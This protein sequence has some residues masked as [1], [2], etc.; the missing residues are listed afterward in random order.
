[1][2]VEVRIK[3]CSKMSRQQLIAS[4]AFKATRLSGWNSSPE[5]SA[6]TTQRLNMPNLKVPSSKKRDSNS[7]LSAWVTLNVDVT[8]PTFSSMLYFKAN[9]GQESVARVCEP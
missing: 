1:M 8:S 3:A 4:L 2:G 7:A 6:K 5:V 9:D